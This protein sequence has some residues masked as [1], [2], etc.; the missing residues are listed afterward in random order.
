MK[1]E[2]VKLKSLKNNHTQKPIEQHSSDTPFFREIG[3]PQMLADTI[4]FDYSNNS[5]IS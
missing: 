4:F 5:T 2:S 1:K 3:L